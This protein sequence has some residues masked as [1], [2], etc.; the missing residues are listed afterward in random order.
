MI[1]RLKNI[2]QDTNYLDLELLEDVVIELKQAYN[3]VS[4]L[5]ASGTEN[6]RHT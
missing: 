4:M 2:F 6:L 5:P 1:G 3:T